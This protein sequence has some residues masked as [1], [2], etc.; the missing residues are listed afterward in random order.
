VR[1]PPATELAIEAG[2]SRPIMGKVLDAMVASGELTA[3][4]GSDGRVVALVPSRRADRRIAVLTSFPSLVAGEPGEHFQAGGASALAAHVAVGQR[5][6]ELGLPVWAFDPSLMPNWQRAAIAGVAV[7]PECAM[8]PDVQEHVRLLLGQGCPV[9]IAGSD[10]CHAG[11]DRVTSDH[12]Q[13]GAMVT[14]WLLDRGC[15]RILPVSVFDP[16]Q[17]WL[18]QRYLGYC[19]A[20]NASAMPRQRLLCANLGPIAVASFVDLPQQARALVGYLL[21]AFDDAAARPDAL[22]CAND[23]TAALAIHALR[24]LG[25]QPNRDVLVSGYDGLHQLSQRSWEPEPPAVT[26]FQR[27]PAQGV[28]LADLLAARLRGETGPAREILV[29]PSVVEVAGAAATASD[30]LRTSAR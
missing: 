16:N 12:Q 2:V 26:V 23:V 3:Q 30:D 7:M 4:R 10:Y 21:P 20:M 1:L 25:V 5:L 17:A 11:F 18:R 24:Y 27:F 15:R 22:M 29:A 28:A 8:L 14:Q 9:V 13:G 6:R 19:K